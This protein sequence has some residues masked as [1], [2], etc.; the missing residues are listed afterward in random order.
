M[1]LDSFQVLVGLQLSIVRRAADML[2]L[3]F[4]DIRV[5]PSGEGTVGAYAL[6]ARCAWRFDGPGR[7]ITGRDDLW[8]YAGPG[9]RPPN[10]S[11]EDGFSLQDLRFS[12]FFARDQSTRSWVNP[13]GRFVVT[14]TEQ[15]KLGDLRVSLTE[16]YAILLFPAGSGSEAWRLFEPGRNDAHFV[17]PTTRRDYGI[18]R[19]K[20]AGVSELEVSK[21][22]VA[23]APARKVDRS[24]LDRLAAE[25]EA[26]YNRMY[27]AHNYRDAKDAWDDCSLNLYRA[28]EEAKRLGLTE[29]A[30]RLSAR[31][32]HCH[33]VWN[34]QFRSAF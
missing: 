25:G 2:V 19:R 10:W 18:S 28:T 32:D 13:G 1:R 20:V 26:A 3:H 21:R 31:W 12:K 9:Q 15:T 23:P 17:F 7:T 34:S 8:K 4:G 27:D 24:E 11:H 5:H 16:G 33:A 6:H 29:D 30:E 22:I 14:G